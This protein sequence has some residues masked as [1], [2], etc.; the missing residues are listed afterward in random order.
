MDI[1]DGTNPDIDL[2]IDYVS[3]KCQ[4]A[5]MAVQFS[6]RAVSQPPTF[7]S[8]NWE[9]AVNGMKSVFIVGTGFLATG[10]TA[11]MLGTYMLEDSYPEITATFA[12]NCSVSLSTVITDDTGSTQAGGLSGRKIE[13]RNHNADPSVA[14]VTV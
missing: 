12:T 11:A 9:S 5:S 14:W 13:A 3:L 10:N 1:L 7:C 4:M 8:E 6:R 2:E